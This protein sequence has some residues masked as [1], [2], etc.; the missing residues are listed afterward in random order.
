MKSQVTLYDP[1][2]EWRYVSYMIAEQY[3]M[4][5]ALHWRGRGDSAGWNNSE[6]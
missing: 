2:R 3:D 6:R 1:K 5:V 4:D